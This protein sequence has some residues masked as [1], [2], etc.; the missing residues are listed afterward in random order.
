MLKI[1]PGTKDFLASEDGRIFDQ[2][3]NERNYYHN[4]DGY[5]T[6]SVILDDGTRCTFGVHRLIALTFLIIPSNVRELTVNHKDHD[7]RNNHVSN[8]E[9]ATV[10]Q[11]NAHASMMRGGKYP[12][13]LAVNANNEM[14]F[15][16]S[17]ISASEVIGKSPVEIW[18]AIKN[19]DLI[20]GW[21]LKHHGSKDKIPECLKKEKI[22]TRNEY[23]QQPKKKLKVKDFETNEI[24]I[25]NSLR[26]AADYFN[27]TPSHIHHSLQK[28]NEFKLLKKRY[29]LAYTEDDFIIPTDYEYDVAIN[30]GAKEVVAYSKIYK[31]IFIALS[32]SNFIKLNNLS[33]KAVTTILK[34]DKIRE[35]DGWVFLYNN[36]KNLKRIKEYIESPVSIC[37]A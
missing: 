12:R 32:A 34:S 23:G 13:I 15:F 20:V 7:I 21:S 8:L 35:V 18:S 3:G 26:E 19:E 4:K 11:N 5:K 17:L 36:D 9:W 25:F 24:S 37:S 30:M 33:K 14:M 2:D 16:N 31:K 10:K 1:I 28:D 29:Q 6:V 27:T 22:K